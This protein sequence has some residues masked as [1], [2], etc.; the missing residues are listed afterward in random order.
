M[1]YSTLE[2]KLSIVAVDYHRY[3]KVKVEHGILTPRTEHRQIFQ[4]ADSACIATDQAGK[5]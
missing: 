2:T 4:Q 5:L 1:H 3:E